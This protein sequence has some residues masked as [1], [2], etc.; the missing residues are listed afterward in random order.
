[1]EKIIVLLHKPHSFVDLI[2]NSSTE[3][4]VIDKARTEEAFKM[5]I[6]FLMEIA[7]IDYESSIC[8]LTDSQ[9]LDSVEIPEGYNIDDLYVL[10]ASYH[11][12][13]LKELMDHFH[14]VS[15]INL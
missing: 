8:K 14:I 9:Y 1:M 6:D 2:T 7:E 15:N 13:L 4:Y 3:I 5:V 12:T 10:Y 11:N